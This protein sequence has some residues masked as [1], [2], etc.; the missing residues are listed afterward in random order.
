MAE[1]TLNLEISSQDVNLLTIAQERIIVAKPVGSGPPNVA[2]LSILPFQG[3][4]IVWEELFGL[5]ASNAEIENGAAINQLDVSEPFPA[6]PQAFYTYANGFS[7]PTPTPSELG[8]GDYGV[9]NADSRFDFLTFGLHQTATI[10][11]TRTTDFQPLNAAIALVPRQIVFTPFTPVYIWTQ[12][13]LVSRTVIT[14]ITSQRTI[15]TFGAGVTELTFRYSAGRF[16][17][18]GSGGGLLTSA[19]EIEKAGVTFETHALL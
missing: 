18:V 16:N 15:G 2:W 10:N 9:I 13:N 7:G 5:Y 1:F 12:A 4:T 14:R 6:T 3:T 8:L 17:P 11:G 19:K